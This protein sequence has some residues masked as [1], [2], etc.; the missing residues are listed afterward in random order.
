MTPGAG[1]PPG[2]GPVPAEI[3]AA[4]L[5]AELG[6]AEDVLPDVFG[7]R[8]APNLREALLSGD[9][10]VLDWLEE[11]AGH[12]DALGLRIQVEHIHGGELRLVTGDWSRI[13]PT[14][15]RMAAEVKAG[16]QFPGE[17]HVTIRKGSRQLPRIRFTIAPDLESK[18]ATPE[19]LSVRD[20]LQLVREFKKDRGEDVERLADLDGAVAD[21]ENRLTRIEDRME[22]IWGAVQ[23]AAT[24]AQQAP[25]S[26]PLGGLGALAGL[27]DLLKMFQAPQEV[28]TVPRAASTPDANAQQSSRMGSAV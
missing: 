3:E 11:Q 22:A 21:V 17:Y 9:A 25:A 2:S 8:D 13:I 5:T 10:L 28:D 7:K 18:A 23:Q 26:D 14:R 12:S 1:S 15:S 6:R 4:P 16:R 19:S 27:G 20:V 24:Q